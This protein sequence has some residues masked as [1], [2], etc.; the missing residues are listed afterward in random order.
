MPFY[1]FRIRS[2]GRTI[3]TVEKH[4]HNDLD[5]L[6]K[7]E[8]EFGVRIWRGGQEIGRLAVQNMPSDMNGTGNLARMFA[9]DH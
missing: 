9:K 4:C 6:K 5:A 7:A 1:E 2:Q 8:T 3:W